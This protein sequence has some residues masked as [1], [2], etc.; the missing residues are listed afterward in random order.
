MKCVKHSSEIKNP[1]I[2]KKEKFY[3]IKVHNTKLT[4][5]FQRNAIS[6]KH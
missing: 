5:K 4:K 6:V 1:D 3:D 2:K